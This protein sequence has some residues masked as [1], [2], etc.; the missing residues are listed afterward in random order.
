METSLTKRIAQVRDQLGAGGL[1]VADFFALHPSEAS[2]FSAQEIARRAEVSD[3]T[4]IR[5]VKQLGYSG[6]GELR[7]AAAA[8]VNPVRDPEQTLAEHLTQSDD[9][10][11]L[12]AKMCLDAVQ[13]ARALPATVPTEAFETAARIV[14]DAAHTLIVGYGSALPL[15]DSLSLGLRRIGWVASATGQTGYNFADE[16][17]R[18]GPG[19]ALVLIAPLRHVREHDVAISEAKRAGCPIVLVTEVL[20]SHFADRVDTVLVAPSTEDMLPS[21]LLGHLLILDALLLAVAATDP[22]R[23]L[24]GWKTTNRLRGELVDGN[25]DVPLNRALASR[26]RP[27]GDDVTE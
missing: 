11:R 14:A 20:A 21:T 9:S 22:D 4:V 1:R 13:L 19:S 24:D 2:V 7:R 18:L 15:A 6:L 27:R 5:T 23:A 3:A 12:L 8:T 10:S 17:G 26:V 25:L 16:L